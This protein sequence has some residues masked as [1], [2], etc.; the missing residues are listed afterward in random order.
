[1]VWIIHGFIR[2]KLTDAIPVQLA[3]IPLIVF[4]DIVRDPV[5]VEVVLNA[6]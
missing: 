3:V 1:M 5:E 2:E 4:E 6:A